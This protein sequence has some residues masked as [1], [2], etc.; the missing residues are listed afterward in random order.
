M[1]FNFE[2]KANSTKSEELKA[3]NDAKAP[4]DTNELIDNASVN[5]EKASETKAEKSREKAVV[6]YIG[7]G[8]WRDED[9]ECWS[10][11][12]NSHANILN[13]RSYSKCDYENRPDLQF[14]VKYGE[15][16][17]TLV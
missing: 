6:S 13:T 10:R 5:S 11:N 7:N 9:G 15:M 1:N 8:V 16:R 14:M 2:T 3:V 4:A 17:V 12:E